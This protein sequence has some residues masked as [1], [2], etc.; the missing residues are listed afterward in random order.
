[1]LVAWVWPILLRENLNLCNKNETGGDLGPPPGSGRPTFRLAHALCQRTCAHV[2]VVMCGATEVGLGDDRS[3]LPVSTSAIG[4][5][6]RVNR[7]G[8]MC[9]AQLDCTR[10]TPVFSDFSLA[11]RPGVVPVPG[12]SYA[13]LSSCST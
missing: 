7:L 4:E 6:A 2:F 11:N 13:T 1:M 3:I 10:P 12:R 9:G 5:P 8:D